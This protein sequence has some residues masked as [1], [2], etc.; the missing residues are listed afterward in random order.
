MQTSVIPSSGSTW[1]KFRDALIPPPVSSCE[2]ERLG[3]FLNAIFVAQ[4]AAWLLVFAARPFSG[5]YVAG[6][7]HIAC[8]VLG[9]VLVRANRLILPRVSVP[10]V[11]LVALAYIEFTGIGIHSFA[12]V[13]F[14]LAIILAA[15]SLGRWGAIATLAAAMGVLTAVYGA[16]TAGIIHTPFT[17]ALEPSDLVYLAIILSMN[18]VFLWILIGWMRSDL[19]LAQ[20]GEAAARDAADE[21][22][23]QREALVQS[24]SRYRLL[25]ENA[26]DVVQV[27]GLDLKVHYVSPSIE[28]QRG[29]TVA[30]FMSM[31]P[32]ELVPPDWLEFLARALTEELSVDASGNADPDRSR[33]F[34]VQV[35][36]KGGSRIWVES[37][38]TAI[39]NEAGEIVE[40]LGVTRDINDRKAAEAE[41]AVLQHRMQEMQR[42]E[43]LGILAGGIA[44]D[45][46]NLLSGILGNADLALS[47]MREGEAGRNEISKVVRIAEDAADLSRQLLAYSGKG[48]FAVRSVDISALLRDMTRVLGLTAGRR[49]ELKL[50][51][52]QGL[53]AIEVDV[54]QFRQVIMNLVINAAEAMEGRPGAVRIHSG[55]KQLS[56][57]DLGLIA[58]E[59]RRDPGEYVY[60]EIADSG[61]GMSEATKRR[62]FEP[63]FTTKP[64]GHGLGLA[65]TLGIVRA[66]GGAVNVYSELGIG[67][68]VRVYLPKSDRAVTPLTEAAPS[69]GEFRGSGTVLVADDESTVRG[70]V[71]AALTRR[72]FDVLTATNGLEAVE[73]VKQHRAALRLIILDLTMPVMSGHE[74]MEK[75]REIDSDV[76]VLLTSGF[77]E[78][79]VSNN[80]ATAAYTGFLQKPYKLI[81]LDEAVRLALGL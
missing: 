75:I 49:I 57:A 46:N 56:G 59:A 5:A 71:T 72:G 60:F 4:I 52:A 70:M 55:S 58:D 19:R 10:L 14:P 54:T 11:A 50:E 69:N 67:T 43:S 22:V 41:R 77:S 30:E 63:F 42:T 76:P 53:P 1:E 37:V 20:E 13:A 27:F 62:I 68:T 73:C 78:Q 3:R 44:H 21:I 8:S 7:I 79:Q 12:T 74:A 9:L 34:E 33:R 26:Q 61:V 38:Y 15:V 17:D 32:D 48:K 35:F 25:A 81:E 31:Q 47:R 23:L 64:S 36:T 39:R 29:F 40:L 51:L 45:F 16:E 28:K 6:T 80:S 24:E 65:A 66:H 18:L 2:R